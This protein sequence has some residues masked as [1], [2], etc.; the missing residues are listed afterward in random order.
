MTTRVKDI[1]THFEAPMGKHSEKPE[2]FFKIAER[3][4]YP[5][6]LEV[7]ARS[8]REGWQVWGAGVDPK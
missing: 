8:E 4:S 7:F 5:P 6:Y 2:K 3:A 1:A